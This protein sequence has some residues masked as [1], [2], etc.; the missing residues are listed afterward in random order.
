MMPARLGVLTIVLEVTDAITLKDKRQVV[1]SVLDRAAQ[2]FNVA[3]AEV[4]L[5]D[6]RRRA[7]LAFA[8]VANDG[9][10]VADVLDSVLRYVEGDPRATVLESETELV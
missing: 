4:G 9:K 6:S 3:V 8:C 7:E 10:H 5:L 1:Q 2:R